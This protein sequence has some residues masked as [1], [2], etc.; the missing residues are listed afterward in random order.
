MRNWLSPSLRRSRRQISPRTV[1]YVSQWYAPEPFHTPGWTADG[2][3]FRGWD[4]T[5]LT[6]VPNYPDGKI[7]PGYSAWC[8]LTEF[9]MGRKIIRA[10]LFPSHDR[11]AA[12]RTLNYVSWALS[13][14]V[15]GNRA[16]SRSAV[17]YVY[18]SPATA[19]LP[20]LFA[21]ILWGRP[22][23]LSVQDVWPDSV[24]ASGFLTKGLIRRLA[25]SLLSKFVELTYELAQHVVVIS[26]GMRSLLRERGVPAANISLVYNWVDESLFRPTEPDLSFRQRLGLDP[27]DFLVVYAGNHGAAQG[28]RTAIDAVYSLPPELRIHLVL[29]GDG[30]EKELLRA[31]AA[32]LRTQRIH[33]VGLMP[34]SEVAAATASCE[35]QLVSLIDEPLFHLTIPSKMQAIMAMAQPL[36][37]A[38][39]GDAA[40]MVEQS[41]AGFAITPEDPSALAEAMSGASR[42][43]RSE[44][45]RMGQNGRRL[46][47]EQMSAEV[48]TATLSQ[49]LEAAVA[50]APG[51]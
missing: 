36:L 31:H 8:P 33:F 13:A 10:P 51:G 30:V 47:I 7:H 20:A 16:L 11:S 12:R 43:P 9:R 32:Q 4:V 41:D 27:A 42:L 45:R 24:F 38:V 46:Y 40:A 5:V 26:P 23:V 17:N 25:E 37:V 1:G 35:I 50:A 44:L 22:Y 48:G 2:L 19:A 28:L 29:I 6:G 15:V 49:I 34:A 21:R 14:S 18:S 3:A 39:P